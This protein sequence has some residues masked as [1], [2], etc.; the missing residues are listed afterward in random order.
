MSTSE[1]QLNAIRQNAQKSTGPKTETGKKNS[2]QNAITHG[3]HATDIVLNSPHLTE[4]PTLYDQLVD[5]LF[6]ELKPIGG[7]PAF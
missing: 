1:K 6:E 7:W 5:S 2:S 3:L 4:S